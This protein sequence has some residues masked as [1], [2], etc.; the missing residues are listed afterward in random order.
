MSSSNGGGEVCAGCCWGP[1]RVNEAELR[2]SASG[3]VEALT[4]RSSQPANTDTPGPGSP[5]RRPY[6]TVCARVRHPRRHRS[7]SAQGTR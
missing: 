1:A 3:L 2:R 5:S 4:P 6:L 7:V